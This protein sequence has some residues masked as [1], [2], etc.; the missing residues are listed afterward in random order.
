METKQISELADLTSI[1]V[2]KNDVDSLFKIYTFLQN[3]LKEER[4]AFGVLGI[5]WFSSSLTS[6]QL[7][8]VVFRYENKNS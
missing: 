2:E 8:D 3:K 6:Q 1:A 7:N 5:E 4:N